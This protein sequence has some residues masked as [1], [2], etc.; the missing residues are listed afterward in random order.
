VARPPAAVLAGASGHG[1][2]RGEGQNGED[3]GVRFPSS[4]W[5]AVAHG[6]RSTVVVICGRG[7]TRAAAWGAQEGDGDGWGGAQRGGERRG[8]PLGGGVALLGT[9]WVHEAD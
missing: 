7:G 8:G 9:L 3:E 2:G 4:P 1:G 6:G 5:A